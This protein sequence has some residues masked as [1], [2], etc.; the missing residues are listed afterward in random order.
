MISKNNENGITLIYL[1]II[2]IIILIISAF[3]VFSFEF[4]GVFISI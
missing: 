1:I 4:E 2:L 3:I